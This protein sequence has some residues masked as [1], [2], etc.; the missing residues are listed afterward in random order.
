[1]TL[2]EFTD[3]I[4]IQISNNEIKEAIDQLF[5]LLEPL[6]NEVLDSLVIIRSK[7]TMLRDQALR[8]LLDEDQQK[9]AYSHLCK[10]LL[11]IISIVERD[12]K[13]VAHYEKRRKN[14]IPTLGPDKVFAQLV[15]TDPR[16]SRGTVDVSGNIILGRSDA[17]DVIVNEPRV[18][19]QHARLFISDGRPYI[20]DLGSKNKTYL[21]Q[22]QIFEPTLISGD[23]KILLY[24][25][26]F[27]I[28][29]WE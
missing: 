29:V 9:T 18:S 8:S 5:L 12:N 2:D 28:K 27:E 6:E 13:I 1:M 16:V 24:D 7:H 19:R 11:D 23:S 4:R 22:Q 10:N 17:C 25:V 20:E 21:N 14:I 3:R 15:C 26:A